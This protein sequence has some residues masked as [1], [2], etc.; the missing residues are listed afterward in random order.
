MSNLCGKAKKISIRNG[1]P[2]NQ[3]QKR[4]ALAGMLRE[5]SIEER[6]GHAVF[7]M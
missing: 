1:G 2:V 5:Q 7:S 4:F 6:V 3:S